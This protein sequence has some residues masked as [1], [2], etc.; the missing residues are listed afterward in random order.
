MA[1]SRFKRSCGHRPTGAEQTIKSA[2]QERT[3]CS[4][5]HMECMKGWCRC[6][7]P[8]VVIVV[9]VS[10]W[11]LPVSAFATLPDYAPFRRAQRIDYAPIAEDLLRLWI[12]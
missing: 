9:V 2:E 12:V 4:A 5:L 3:G 11:L 7:A 8:V 6:I 10:G 1:Q